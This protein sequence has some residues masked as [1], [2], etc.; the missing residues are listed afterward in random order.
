MNTYITGLSA[1]TVDDKSDYLFLFEYG[2]HDTFLLP[3]TLH[4]LEN[5]EGRKEDHHPIWHDPGKVSHY[6]TKFEQL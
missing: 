4:P 3:Y 5:F 2:A 6:L 1:A